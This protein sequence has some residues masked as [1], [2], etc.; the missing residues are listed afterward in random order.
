MTGD[1]AGLA[2]ALSGEGVGNAL[3]SGRVAAFHLIKCFEKNNYSKVFNLKYNKEIYQRMGREFYNYRLLQY[4]FRFPAV[5]NFLIGKV[6][7]HFID[8]FNKPEYLA[9]FQGKRFFLL[10]L[11][12][13]VIFH[14][15]G[16]N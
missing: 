13:H 15:K 3:R 5:V 12:N 1:A 4:L 10:R 9:Q 11:L 2:N 8:I 6:G 14:K 16:N 7:P